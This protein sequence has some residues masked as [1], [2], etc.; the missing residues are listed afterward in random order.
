MHLFDYCLFLIQFCFT[1]LTAYGRLENAKSPIKQDMHDI[2]LYRNSLSHSF[3]QQGIS[4]FEDLK[5]NKETFVYRVDR[6]MVDLE[7]IR[8]ISSLQS[9]NELLQSD[10]ESLQSE[11]SSLEEEVRRLSS[12]RSF[13]SPRN[14]LPSVGHPH[15]SNRSPQGWHA[16]D[17]LD[18]ELSS[19]RRSQVQRQA[20]A[21]RSNTVSGKKRHWGG[22]QKHGNNGNKRQK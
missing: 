15:S 22:H 9:Q 21:E 11:K 4:T 17:A 6:V 13:G 12:R 8:E 7:R 2:R 10:N 16:T 18:Q 5:T 1:L 3:N 19:P 20:N 14:L